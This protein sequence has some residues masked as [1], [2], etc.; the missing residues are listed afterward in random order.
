MQSL[1][2]AD[3]P[4]VFQEF[5]RSNP[6]T[7][8]HSERKHSNSSLKHYLPL[9]ELIY[10]LFDS[11]RET[12]MIGYTDFSHQDIN[13]IMRE[14]GDE[15]KG[16]KYHLLH[17]N[18][19]HFTEALVKVINIWYNEWN[20]KLIDFI[21]FMRENDPLLDQSISVY[22]HLCPIPRTMSSQRVSNTCRSGR[23]H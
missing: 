3:I 11:C 21:V 17:K 20:I 1:H 8:N 6:K 15:Y 18:C 7:W 9:N 16:D 2:T 5:L 10:W 4:S 19:N 13:Q 14:M 12:I 23:V 22:K